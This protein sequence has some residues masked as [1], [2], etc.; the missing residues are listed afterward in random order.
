MRT[1]PS[2]PTEGSSGPG[3]P[4]GHRNTRGKSSRG[5]EAVRAPPPSSAGRPDWKNL[6][7]RSPAVDRAFAQLDRRISG[8]A[9]QW[10]DR[11][12]TPTL[13]LLREAQDLAQRCPNELAVLVLVAKRRIQL[14]RG[15]RALRLTDRE[16]HEL[17][18]GDV[19]PAI[20]ELDR[21][22]FLGIERVGHDL[23]IRLG[24]GRSEERRV[25]N[26]RRARGA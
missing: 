7:A 16:V 17:T 2:R 25:G 19:V 8:S 18:V 13:R 22:N 11:L 23:D 15:D 14:V 26:E 21:A 9:H 4:A 6:L 12:A 3:I 20:G 10:G 24:H 1:S 5:Y